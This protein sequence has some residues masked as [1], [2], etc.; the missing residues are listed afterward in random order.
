MF[1]AVYWWRVAPGKEEQ[2]RA[3]WRRGT[4]LI[5]QRYGSLGSRLHQERDGRFVGYAEWPDEATW[6]KAFDAKMVYDDRETRAAFVDA[7]I[8]TPPN[9]APAFTM[10]VT[11]DLLDRAS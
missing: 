10:T 8:E 5:R 3:A 1:V 4:A 9:N 11:D 6:Q 2:F 7:V